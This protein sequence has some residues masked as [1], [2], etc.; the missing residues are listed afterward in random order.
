MLPRRPNPR[1]SHGTPYKR[2]QTETHTVIG[3]A[4]ATHADK[5]AVRGDAFLGRDARR[6]RPREP[7]AP[8][9][10]APQA[11]LISHI[12]NGRESRTLFC[13]LGRGARSGRVRRAR[14]RALN[15][16]SVYAKCGWLFCAQYRCL[17]VYLCVCVCVSVCV[18]VCWCCAENTR[19]GGAQFIAF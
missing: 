15:D 3:I 13:W 7:V 11:L 4:H 18:C 12:N 1:S 5:R 10:A 9:C 8:P 16:E 2:R 17:W 14:A 6:T 19:T